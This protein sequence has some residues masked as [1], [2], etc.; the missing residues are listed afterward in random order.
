MGQFEITKTKNGEFFFHLKASNGQTLMK[1]EKYMTKDSTKKGIESVRRNSADRSKFDVFEPKGGKPYF[2]LRAVNGRVVA[3][4]EPY[5][6]VADRDAAL[7]TVYTTA[8][9]AKI[10]DLSVKK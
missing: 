5:A 10:V 2:S 4:S 3:S 1:S 7:K 6:N 8:S 9:K